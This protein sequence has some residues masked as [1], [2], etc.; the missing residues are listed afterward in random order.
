MYFSFRKMTLRFVSGFH[1]HQMPTGVWLILNWEIPVKT[2]VFTLK[3]R[4]NLNFKSITWIKF[5]SFLKYFLPKYVMSRVF[6]S[7]SLEIEV[8]STHLLTWP[9]DL[10]EYVQQL[11]WYQL[12]KTLF[13]ACL[14]SAGLLTT[15]WPDLNDIQND[16]KN[17]CTFM[18]EFVQPI[19]IGAVHIG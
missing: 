7:K 12:Y 16:T 8:R 11:L 15:E 2:W 17:N 4:E 18:A 3:G 9:P 6:I 19:N 1:F 14:S 10:W 5:G 13:Q